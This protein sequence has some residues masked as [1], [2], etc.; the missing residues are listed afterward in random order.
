MNVYRTIGAATVA[1]VLACGS[2]YWWQRRPAI[3][4]APQDESTLMAACIERS[5][6]CGRTCDFV[7]STPESTY[8]RIV[9]TETNYTYV[10]N[11]TFY[12]WLDVTGGDTTLID[13]QGEVDA[14]PALGAYRIDLAGDPNIDAYGELHSGDATLHAWV[15][16][17]D[18]STVAWIVRDGT[19]WGSTNA[20]V[21]ANFMNPTYTGLPDC[22]PYDAVTGSPLSSA[23]YHYYTISPVQSSNTVSITTNETHTPIY[24]VYTNAQALVLTNTV[25][26]YPRIYRY[27]SPAVTELSSYVL[28]YWPTNAPQQTV[29]LRNAPAFWA[30]PTNTPMVPFDDHFGANVPAYLNVERTWWTNYV[31]LNTTDAVVVHIPGSPS[32]VGNETIP[33]AYNPPHFA[34]ERD[35]QA[36]M[37][38]TNMLNDIARALSMMQWQA[39]GS[40]IVRTAQVSWVHDQRVQVVDGMP[41]SHNVRTYSDVVQT[42]S[43]WD[44]SDCL[45]SVPIVRWQSKVTIHW[46]LDPIHFLP[47]P[48]DAWREDWWSVSYYLGYVM[49]PSN[50]TCIGWSNVDS[51]IQSTCSASSFGSWTN[52][53]YAMPVKTLVNSALP[54]PMF[55]R[56]PAGANGVCYLFD[57]GL[58][59]NQ[60]DALLDRY[61]TCIDIPEQPFPDAPYWYC[62][63]AGNGYSTEGD[64]VIRSWNTWRCQFSEL[65][66]YVDHAP[67]R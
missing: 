62:W 30:L 42:Q 40:F 18:G 17:L 28:P 41:T 52:T 48:T 32:G 37:W 47:D 13:N 23:L 3:Q 44:V 26:V 2:L 38:S 55:H 64:V 60:M 56:Q 65:T 9:A 25:G 29:P 61:V 53:S 45:A 22:T 46:T 58:T 1:T 31:T 12:Y 24:G 7:D 11:T 66:N 15:S 35:R 49:T 21:W 43:M 8:T 19:D 27:A 50:S 54:A 39:A 57:P 6:A 36:P 4:P 20:V 5:L 59:T 34:Y 10:T 63:D 14:W 16:W 67:A 33:V 51:A